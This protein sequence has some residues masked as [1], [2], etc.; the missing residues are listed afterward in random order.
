VVVAV[1]LIGLLLWAGLKYSESAEENVQACIDDK[2][3][4]NWEDYGPAGMSD[5]F[6]D[7]AEDD[8]GANR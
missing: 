8:C 1:A 2:M 3:A 5:H 6:R 7:E 4:Q